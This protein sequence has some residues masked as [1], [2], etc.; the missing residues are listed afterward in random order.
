MMVCD[1]TL[2]RLFFN[3]TIIRKHQAIQ[4]Q[5]VT[6][7]AAIAG[8]SVGLMSTHY[9]D[10]EDYLLAFTAGGFL[11]LATVTILSSREKSAHQSSVAQIALEVLCFATGIAMMV[12]VAIL[13]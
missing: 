3:G 9:D 6:A 11:H 13:E 12:A 4:A 7:V 5:F 2:S 1:S 10:A 8:T